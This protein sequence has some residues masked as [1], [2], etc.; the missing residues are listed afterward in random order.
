MNMILTCYSS[1]HNHAISLI[2]STPSIACLSTIIIS[3]DKLYRDM[4]IAIHARHSSL[5]LG[6]RSHDVNVADVRRRLD[7][8]ST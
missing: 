4:D 1:I 7:Q 5:S 2:K 3:C 8:R 6:G